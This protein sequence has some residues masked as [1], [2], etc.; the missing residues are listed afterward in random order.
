MAD[1]FQPFGTNDDTFRRQASL[2][3]KSFIDASR[4]AID[5]FL[6]KA[7]VINFPQS[8]SK[9]AASQPEYATSAALMSL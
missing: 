6:S 1:G 9:F 2:P 3:S 5:L 4:D 8:P 7:I